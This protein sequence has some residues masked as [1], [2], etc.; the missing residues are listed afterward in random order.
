MACSEYSNGLPSRRLNG[1]GV[2]CAMSRGRPRQ[3]YQN[4]PGNREVSDNSSTFSLLF[5]PP[6]LVIHSRLTLN[7]KLDSMN[8]LRKP[9]DLSKILNRL[10][11][12]ERRG[13]D[14]M[15]HTIRLLVPFQRPNVRSSVFFS[16]T[17]SHQNVKDNPCLE[18]SEMEGTRYIQ[19][20]CLKWS[21][22][23]NTI[24]AS[25]RFSCF[26]FFFGFQSSRESHGS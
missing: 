7:F 12:Q 11:L 6:L 25:K 22:S 23:P 4:K 9:L 3:I 19:P 16:Q 20:C 1:S 21:S 15:S 14:S 5:L 17:S 18:V 13:V 26:V 24:S 8:F 2:H 10:C